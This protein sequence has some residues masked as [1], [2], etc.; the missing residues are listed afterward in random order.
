MA[1]LEMRTQ[2]LKD[3]IHSANGSAIHSLRELETVFSDIHKT[4]LRLNGEW[5][6]D[7]QRIFMASF[8]RKNALIQNYI[9]ALHDFFGDVS[10]SADKIA[11][12]DFFLSKKI[13]EG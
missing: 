4:A 9:R 13:G 11:D 8:E 1:R 6:D 10:A 7:A 5:D 2:Q 12:W 3:S